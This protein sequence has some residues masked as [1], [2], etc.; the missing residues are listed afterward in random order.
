MMGIMGW[1]SGKLEKDGLAYE[2]EEAIIGHHAS[3]G[4]F[5]YPFS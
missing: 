1:S 3:T 5:W 4:S 2:S